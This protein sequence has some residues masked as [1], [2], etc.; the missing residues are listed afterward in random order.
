ML[1]EKYI[2]KNHKLVKKD[3]AKEQL[4]MKKVNGNC[5]YWAKTVKQKWKRNKKDHVILKK[6][7]LNFDKEYFLTKCNKK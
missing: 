2:S 7:L 3:A 6:D 1:G 5:S 4:V